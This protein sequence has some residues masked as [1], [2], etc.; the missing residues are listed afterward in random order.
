MAHEDDVPLDTRA[1]II[2][3]A[4][5]LIASGGND[6]ATTRA[7]A[8]AAGVQAPTIYRLFGDKNGLLEAVAEQVLTAFIVAKGSR[9]PSNDPVAD[10]LQGWDDYIAFG[11]ANPAIFEIMN[12]NP[13]GRMSTATT[14]GIAILRER[15]RRVARAG[16]LSLSEELAT[17]IIH[18][19]GLG[20]VL[21]LLAKPAD[22]RAGF[23][24]AARDAIMSLVIRGSPSTSGV[25]AMAS[26]LRANLDDLAQLSP[27]ERHL[28]GELLQ[29]IADSPGRKVTM[30]GPA[31]RNKG[32]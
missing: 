31:P 14:A 32:R 16:R 10:L 8:T 25:A 23:A 30:N 15:V 11:V 7:V 18:A 28:L 1:R 13:A 22:G 26:G 9:V 3:A 12:V 6:A 24:L 4:T 2:A 20:T 5:E 19:G 17:D 29:R 27:G 21:T